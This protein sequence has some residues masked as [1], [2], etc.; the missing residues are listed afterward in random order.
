MHIQ[1]VVPDLFPAR[2]DDGLALSTDYDVRIPAL[3]KLLARA[4]RRITPNAQ[5]GEWLAATL[6]TDLPT[7][8]TALRGENLDPGTRYWF[9]TDPVHVE[10]GLD[11]LRLADPTLLSID[12]AE[13]DA[14]IA[15]LA[16]HFHDQDFIWHAPS[17]RR[18]YLGITDIPQ[19]VTTPINDARTKAF[20]DAMPQGAHAARWRGVLNEIQMV[21]HEHPVNEARAARGLPP[22][23]GVWIAEGGTWAAPRTDGPRTNMD[24]YADDPVS[25]GLAIAADCTL[26]PRPTHF[27]QWHAQ[28]AREDAAHVSVVVL[29]AA[30]PWATRIAQLEADW[31]APIETALSTGTLGMATLVAVAD[32]PTHE[33]ALIAEVTR[34]DLRFFWRRSRPLTHYLAST[35]QP[36]RVA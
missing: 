10:V 21:L 5:L 36:E 11:S 32:D 7:A 17:P 8:A 24:C 26:N 3:E 15:T 29:E 18:W 33:S 2:H 13:A 28:S 31:F 27:A 16:A 6:G 19:I 30:T 22:I 34:R 35:H 4:R 23:N 9:C 1:L 25:R 20:A 14:L 12:R